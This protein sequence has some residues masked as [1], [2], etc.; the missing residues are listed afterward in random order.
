MAG[1]PFS[2]KGIEF[3]GEWKAAKKPHRLS[4]HKNPGLEIVLVSKGELKWEVE[5]KAVE[6][7]ANMLFYTLPWQ[8]HGGVEEMQPSCEISYLCLTMAKKY[9][10][11]Q[12]RFQLHPTYGFTTTEERIISSAFL[13][14]RTQAIPASREVAELFSQFFSITRQTGPLRQS[15]TRDTIKLILA[16]LASVVVTGQKPESRMIEA[17]RRVRKFT[18]VLAVRF[19]EPWTLTSMSEACRLGRTQFSQILKKHTGDTPVTY[20]NRTRLREA[21]RLLRESTKSITEIAQD[22]GFNSSQ[23]F[24]TVFKEFTDMDAR[25]F[26]AQTAAT[27]KRGNASPRPMTC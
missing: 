19:A 6:L 10:K 24:A 11:P 23:Y 3:Y 2:I 17:E 14:S 21:Q 5:N 16:Y 7:R 26:R 4:R 13:G 25:S 12:R 20:L 1:D 18:D 9:A 15:R 27:N 22:V 8:E